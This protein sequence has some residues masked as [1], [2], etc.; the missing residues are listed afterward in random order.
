MAGG[1][2]VSPQGG[3]PV[4]LYGPHH[5]R[6]DGQSPDSRGATGRRPWRRAARQSPS[7]ARTGS[8]VNRLNRRARSAVSPARRSRAGHDVLL[9]DSAGS[10]VGAMDCDGSGPAG[11]C[12]TGTGPWAKPPAGRPL[13][14]RSNSS[15]GWLARGS[16]TTEP[17]RS[18]TTS[19]ASSQRSVSMYLCRAALP[20]L[21]GRRAAL[22]GRRPK[23]GHAAGTLSPRGPGPIDSPCAL[24]ITCRSAPGS[25]CPGT[26]G[27]DRRSAGRRRPRTPSV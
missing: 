8:R 17:G 24:R 11:A 6:G 12:V 7:A 22:R 20:H 25:G 27:A 10:G 3:W 1:L 14:L 18:P 9:L 19:W 2:R 15:N 21:G 16:A 23:P 26:L 5:G 13:M 4:R